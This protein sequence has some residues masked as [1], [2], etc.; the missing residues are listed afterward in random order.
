ME[1]KLQSQVRSTAT[2]RIDRAPSPPKRL[3]SLGAP[4]GRRRTSTSA[5]KTKQRHAT[6]TPELPKYQS[7]LKSV[8]KRWVAKIFFIWTATAALLLVFAYRRILWSLAPLDRIE[9]EEDVTKKSV[10]ESMHEHS[11]VAGTKHHDFQNSAIQSRQIAS[12]ATHGKKELHVSQSPLPIF[13]ESI[14]V[15]ERTRGLLEILLSASGSQQQGDEIFPPWPPYLTLYSLDDSGKSANL[16][17]RSDPESPASRSCI[18][19][20]YF[21]VPS[22]YPSDKYEDDW[23]Q[24][25]LGSI[26]DCMVIFCEDSMVDKMR[27][28]RQDKNHT[29]SPTAIVTLRLE[30]LPVAHYYYAS[31]ETALDMDNPATVFWENQL[32]IDPEQKRHRSYQLF[33][34]WLSK[35]WFV[36][37]A[38]ILQHHLFPQLKIKTPMSEIQY[39]MW[40]DIGS[41][42]QKSKTRKQLIRHPDA[43]DAGGD[44]VVVWMAHHDPNPP[45]DPLWN[46]K[47][48]DKEHFYHS[49]S[50]GFGTAT[51]W[52]QFH[53]AFVDT[54]TLYGGKFVGEDQCVLQS[55]CLLHHH[56]CAYVRHDQVPDNRYFG[57]R[58]V[59]RYGPS[60]E[61]RMKP[62]QLWRP[63][64]MSATTWG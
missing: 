54:L 51:A 62:F 55:T 8:T 42:R 31:S 49:G 21:R 33:W 53:A 63:P 29:T 3:Q 58:H 20:A 14:V 7:S 43:L 50:H 6:V 5:W 10:P 44:D 39:W 24:K 38:V 46:R 2:K 34:I 13:P 40:A 36:S 12:T 18:V 4:Q 28:F 60:N 22:K 57:L 17:P 52:I 30:N 26:S 64:N 11:M 25:M 61:E 27:K 59:L 48:H 41:F 47:L 16:L 15:N 35:S 37:T 23:I 19:T 56:L 1:D 9:N 45:K 32:M